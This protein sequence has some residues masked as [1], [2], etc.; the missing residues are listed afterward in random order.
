MGKDELM[1]LKEGF[2]SMAEMI[3]ELITLFDKEE[4]GEDVDDK[5]VHALLG[6]LMM[7][8]MEMKTI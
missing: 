2:L 7:S 8:M 3:D 6:K 5:E 1:K 4:A